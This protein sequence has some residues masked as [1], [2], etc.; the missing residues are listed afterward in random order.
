MALSREEKA[1]R[2]IAR[3]LDSSSLNVALVAQFTDTEMG[4]GQQDVLFDFAMNLINY[5]ALDDMQGHVSTSRAERY[6]LANAC[7]D[8]VK[9]EGYTMG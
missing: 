9:A 3:A 5:W 2:A 4:G 6:I 7:K 8:A 1:S